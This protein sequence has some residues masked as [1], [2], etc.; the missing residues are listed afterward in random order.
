MG[1]PG[2]DGLSFDSDCVLAEVFLPTSVSQSKYSVGSQ[3]PQGSLQVLYYRCGGGHYSFWPKLLKGH[4]EGRRVAFQI[5]ISRKVEEKG[6]VGQKATDTICFSSPHENRWYWGFTPSA[7]LYL[8]CGWPRPLT[9]HRPLQKRDRNG[10]SG[11]GCVDW[12]K[13]VID[14]A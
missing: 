2:G 5:P 8:V 11:P 1:G 12:V 13:S 4:R 10:K 7:P 3:V 14:S 6:E 9:H